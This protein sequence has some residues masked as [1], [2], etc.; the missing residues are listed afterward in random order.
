MNA[1]AV[2]VLCAFLLGASAAPPSFAQGGGVSMQTEVSARRVEV[3]QVFQLQVTALGEDGSSAPSNPR[4]RVPPGFSMQGPSVSTQQ[5]VSISGGSIQQRQGITATWLLS[6][7]RAGLFRVGPASVTTGGGTVQGQTVQIEVVPKGQGAPSQPGARSPRGQQPFD[8]FDPFDIFR[9]RG[10][11]SIP[12]FNAPDTDDT[13]GID[14]LP[15]VP[16]EYRIEHALDKIA[17]LRAT[18]TPGHATLG[19]QITLRIY[20]YGRRGGFR[21]TN[22]SEPSKPDFLSYSLIDT[23]QN[24]RLYPLSID[25]DV[26]YAVKIRELALFP[27]RSG[28]LTIGPMRMGFDG[29]GYATATGQALVRETRPLE[30]TISEPPIDKRPAG[31]ELGTVGRFSLSASV[32]PRTVSA[33]ESV[34]VVVKLEGVGNLPNKLRTPQQ[35]GVE[36]LEPTVV[37]QIEPNN[38]K[39]QGFR[40]FSYVV[41]LVSPGHVELGEMKL[42]FWDAERRHYDVARAALGAIDV[43]PGEHPADAPSEKPEEPLPALLAPRPKLGEPGPKPLHLADTPWFWLVLAGGPLGILLVGSGL[44]MGRRVQQ[45]LQAQRQAAETLASESLRDAQ[46]AL[47]QKDDAAAAGSVERALFLAI[48]AATGLRARAVLKERLQSELE[49]A[50]LPPELSLETAD[51]LRACDELRFLAGSQPGAAPLVERAGRLLPQL[52]KLAGKRRGSRP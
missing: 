43:K 8:P 18:V 23:A 20:A 13:N 45:K 6:S 26:W 51:V 3:G 52:T 17:F 24:E 35:N 21:E 5:Q 47:R 16:D 15:P 11:P 7:P 10:F 32:E 4:L 34:S 22:T 48:E 19:E 28:V 37:E 25:G 50:G 29:R 27:I 42:P 2:L 33:G 40:K 30:V 39:I 36:W 41:R 38:G 1:K 12:G 14:S 49:L 44:S 46:N 31:Y 9:Q